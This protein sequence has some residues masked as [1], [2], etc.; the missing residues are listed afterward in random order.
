M[1]DAIAKL[2]PEAEK[3]LCEM[4]RFPST[5]GQEHEVMLFAE[6]EFKKIPG[7]VVEQ[8]PMSDAIKDDPDY[9]T[10]VPEIKYDGRFNLRVVRKGTGGGKKLIVNAHTDVVPASEG[11][12]DPFNPQVKNGIV[13]GRGACDDKGQVA[14]F[15]LLMKVLDKLGVKTAGDVVGHIVNE[16]E[17]GGNGSLAMARTGE[18]A[19]GCIVLEAS[20]GKLFT[21][22]RGAVW[23]KVIFHGKAGHSGQAGQ[24]KSALLLAR[25]AIAI[26]EKFHAEL[27]KASRGHPLFDP[28]PNPMPITFGK[29][30]AGNWPAAAPSRAQLE[31]VLGLLPNTT[32]EQVMEGMKRA[33][34]ADPS[35]AGNFELAFMYRHDSSVVEPSHPFPQAVL[36]AA[37]QA[38]VPLEVSAMT[39]SCDAWF[40]N[41][42]LKIPT[43]V[44]GP[45]T[46]K[47]AHSKDEQIPL[48][49]IAAA[50]A[51]LSSLV[52]NFCGASR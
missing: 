41:N 46:L 21:S 9:S 29:M 7:L 12:V 10:P 8:V 32:K 40:Y 26:L 30:I 14:T 2:M 3:F 15:Y 38:A 35:I 17:N 6:R 45:G 1:K 25:D 36:A 39:A 13:Y 19:D 23:F 27:L 44:Y 42:Q 28:Y 24:T 11:Q 52:Q 5:P 33:L 48:A 51:L 49:D 18:K 47:V 50:A 4:I 43:V 16:E 37:K 22:I 31:G 34:N 20:E